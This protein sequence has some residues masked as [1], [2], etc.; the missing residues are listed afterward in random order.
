MSLLPQYRKDVKSLSDD[1][2]ESVPLWSAVDHDEPAPAYPP[3]VGE[4]SGGDSTRHNVTYT[5]MPRW[6]IKGTEEHALGVLGETQEETVAIVQRGMPALAAFPAHR[7]EFLSPLPVE[8]SADGRL[9][10]ERWGKILDEAW[11]T[12]KHNPPKALRVQVA[13]LP[14]DGERRQSRER[15]KTA[16]ILMLA[17]S[18]ILFFLAAI[19]CAV[20]GA[21]D[22]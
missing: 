6:P 3:R 22:P 11:P 12:F 4:S 21:F 16:L 9:Q 8:I 15:R 1:Q 20:S 18:P 17:F 7:I 5:F 13:D 10:R 2:E 14:G 19:A